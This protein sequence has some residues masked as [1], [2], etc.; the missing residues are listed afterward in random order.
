MFVSVIIDPGGLDSGK[1]MVDILSRYGFQ[2]IQRSCW[3]S[4]TLGESELSA[5][6][7][8]LDRVTDYYDKIRIYQ[9]PLGG[10][11]VITEMKQKKWRKCS[12]TG[13]ISSK[14]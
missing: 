6:K 11:F 1:M 8:D 5:L 13:N 4:M 9:F 2:K 7:R 14:K 3:E 10:F 12:F